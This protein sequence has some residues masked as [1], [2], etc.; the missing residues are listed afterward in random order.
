MSFKVESINNMEEFQEK[1]GTV[2]KKTAGRWLLVT[3]GDY[4]YYGITTSPTVEARL[5]NGELS[6]VNVKLPLI[7]VN[8]KSW[9]VTVDN[10][11]SIKQGKKDNV[12]NLLA[13]NIPLT[14]ADTIAFGDQLDG[15]F[16][17]TLKE[18]GIWISE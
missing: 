6:V 13:I 18:N 1:G 2:I 4:K 12:N 10:Y 17:E 14:N 16:K 3:I 7:K 15:A 11:G 9:E 8:M 5:G